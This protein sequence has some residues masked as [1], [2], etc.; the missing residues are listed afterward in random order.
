[1]ACPPASLCHVGAFQ[2]ESWCH[3]A[4]SLQDASG[5]GS[6]GFSFPGSF[7]TT[8]LWVYAPG[9][10]IISIILTCLVC[11]GFFFA[12]RIKVLVVRT[13]LDARTCGRRRHA[14]FSRP[15]W[16]ALVVMSCGFSRLSDFCDDPN[17]IR[18]LLIHGMPTSK[19]VSCW[20]FP[21]RVMVPPSL[22]SARC[23]RT[24]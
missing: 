14:Q 19:L 3:L 16:H 7:N 11:Q 6:A 10:S 5:H 12:L 8:G 9:T 20:S 2:S 21:I 18:F 24:W 1:M 4:C 15:V 22:F 17:H 13:E 23:F